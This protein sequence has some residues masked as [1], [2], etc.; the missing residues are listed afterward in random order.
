MALAI[1]ALSPPVTGMAVTGMA[2]HVASHR[3]DAAAPSGR[4]GLVVR[5][6]HVSRCDQHA[7]AH[8]GALPTPQVRGCHVSRCERCPPT[9]HTQRCPPTRH[10][11]CAPQSYSCDQPREWARSLLGGFVTREWARSLLGGFVTRD[12]ASRCEAEL[13]S[14]LT[15]RLSSQLRAGWR[16]SSRSAPGTSHQTRI[17]ASRHADT[18]V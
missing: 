2:S 5:G 7:Y 11:E 10:T 12:W 16:R 9:R 4:K 6:C 18:P 8:N 15:D 1:S 13:T 14:K 3:A 17:L